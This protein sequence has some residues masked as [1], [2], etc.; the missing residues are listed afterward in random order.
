MAAASARRL[1]M[2]LGG[3]FLAGGGLIAAACTTDNG[4]T[5]NVPTVNDSGRDTGNGSSSG[6]SSGGS[7]GDPGGEGGADCGNIPKPKSSDGPFCFSVLD[8][9]PD[10]AAMGVNC[11]AADNKI[12][13]S[14]GRLPNDAGFENSQCVT[15]AEGTEG[16]DEGACGTE[17]DPAFTSEVKEWHC[18][19]AAHCPGTGEICVATVS[20]AGAPKPGQD[21]DFPGCPVYFQSGRFTNGTRCKDSLGA[22]E[23]QM[24]ASDSECKAGKC[25]PLTIEGR[26]GGYCRL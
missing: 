6:G 9:S 5:S 13:C 1:Y 7:S 24:C 26:Y 25:V 17:A 19:E 23:L 2:F 10:G 16:Y 22:G 3:T 4:T 15:A 20:E 11:P 8:A 18:M 12:C 14:G 21:N